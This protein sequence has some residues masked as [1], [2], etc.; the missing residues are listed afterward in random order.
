[1]YYGGFTYTEASNLP[2]PYRRWFIERINSEIAKSHGND[3]N[4]QPQSRAMHENTPESNAL[5][6]RHR[7]ATPSRMTRFS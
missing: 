7:I 3:Q 5:Q 2:V 6:G 1:M 4:S